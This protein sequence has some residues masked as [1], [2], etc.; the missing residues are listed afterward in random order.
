MTRVHAKLAIMVVA[1]SLLFSQ[2]ITTRQLSRGT[3]PDS[4]IS[5][6]AKP[7]PFRYDFSGAR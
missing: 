7:V 2:P 3:Q 6:P 4:E 1:C 5:H